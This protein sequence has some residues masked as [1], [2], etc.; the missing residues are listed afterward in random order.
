MV[1]GKVFLTDDALSSLSPPCDILCLQEG[2]FRSEGS[3]TTRAYK[4]YATKSTLG[5]RGVQIWVRSDWQQGVLGVQTISDRLMTCTVV[6]HGA[7]CFVI[8][9]HAPLNRD[10]DP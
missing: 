1:G 2:R 4:I 7:L 3:Y 10:A 8:S 5:A 9:A 6:I